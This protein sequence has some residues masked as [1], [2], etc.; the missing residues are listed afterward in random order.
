MSDIRKDVYPD[1][2]YNLARQAA[3]SADELEL[4]ISAVLKTAAKKLHT[5]PVGATAL[6]EPVWYGSGFADA[7]DTV[8]EM[9]DAPFAWLREQMQS[10]PVL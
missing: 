2:W 10:G 5:I 1:E 7:I 6:T 9:A 4:F 3:G 8:E